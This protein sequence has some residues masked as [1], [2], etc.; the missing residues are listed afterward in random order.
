MMLHNTIY[1]GLIS[2]IHG[3]IFS[4][5]K[6]LHLFE[7]QGVEKIL[8][9][10]DLVEKGNEGN[11]VIQAIQ[12]NCI[13]C[14]QGNHDILA[15]FNQK[16]IIEGE[17]ILTQDSQEYLKKLPFSLYYVWDN[18]RIRMVHGSPKTCVQYLAHDTSLRQMREAAI[19]SDAEIL[20]AGH[21][22]EPMHAVHC[23]VDFFNP[24]SVCGVNTRDSHTCATLLL[25][26]KKWQVFE[27]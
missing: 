23:G 14:V 2:D 6:A 24:G 11:K 16:D 22:H 15:V 7:K 17:E 4:L 19:D 27:L 13:P 8:C 18:I 10:G 1:L 12:E 21:T 25:P 20:L 5:E 26:Q 9:M 3:D